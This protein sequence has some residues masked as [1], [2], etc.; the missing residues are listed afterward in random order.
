MKRVIVIALCLL[1]S[2]SPAIGFE[3]GDVSLPD[4]IAAGEKSLVL[5]GAGYRTKFFIKAYVGGLYLMEK[6]PHDQA[7]VIQSNDP[8]AIRL[9]IVS[10]LI[11]SQKMV[12]AVTEGFENSTKGNTASIRDRIDRMVE[13]FKEDIKVG[14][15]YDLVYA[16][17]TGMTAS[18]NGILKETFSGVEFKKALFG[19]WLCD[20]P[21]DADLK[22][23]MLGN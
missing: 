8:M 13:V 7:A 4:T 19:I 14:D 5:N 10:S 18:K 1:F 23:K 11:T 21:A 16:P 17:D 20:R 15:V 3:L 12:D 2:S 22:E 6:K 9:H